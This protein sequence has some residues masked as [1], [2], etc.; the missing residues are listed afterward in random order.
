MEKVLNNIKLIL[1]S[2]SLMA[3]L[4]FLLDIVSLTLLINYSIFLLILLVLVALGAAGFNLA[5]NPKGGKSVLI[6]IGA[7]LLFYLIGL[8]M[9]SDSVDSRSQIIIEGS[10]QAEAGIYTLYFVIFSAVATLIYSSVK[11][12]AK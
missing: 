6:G 8:G 2:L 9:A 3:V 1:I 4:L 11:R 7:L 10:K 12:I 5:E